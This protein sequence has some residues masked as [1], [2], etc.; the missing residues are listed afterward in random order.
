MRIDIQ[1]RFRI[2]KNTLI[3]EEDI[4]DMHFSL[5][6]DCISSEQERSSS[7]D[8]GV[9]K[10]GSNFSNSA[11]TSSEHRGTQQKIRSLHN[12]SNCDDF[13]LA[14][15]SDSHDTGIIRV[16][17]SLSLDALTLPH[18]GINRTEDILHTPKQHIPKPS[19]LPPE[20]T[21]SLSSCVEHNDKGI[22]STSLHDSSTFYSALA[23][24]D[25]AFSPACA[26][27]SQI[28][29]PSEERS[30]HT[31]LR[32]KRNEQLQSAPKNILIEQSFT[33]PSDLFMDL[34]QSESSLSDGSSTQAYQPEMLPSSPHLSIRDDS[35]VSLD[36]SQTE[37]PPD[38]CEED[39]ERDL[40]TKGSIQAYLTETMPYSSQQSN[41]DDSNASL[42]QSQT[43]SPPDCSEEDDERDLLIMGYDDHLSYATSIQAYLTE[44]MPSLPHQS[45]RSSTHSDQPEMFPSSPHLSKRDDSNVSI[46]V[47]QS[48][49]P[50]DCSEEDVNE[51]NSAVLSNDDQND[52][53]V[54]TNDTDLYDPLA[55]NE[56]RKYIDFLKSP[57]LFENLN[58]AFDVHTNTQQAAEELQQYYVS[59]PCL[60]S[61]TLEEELTSFRYIVHPRD[62]GSVLTEPE[63]IQDEYY[64]SIDDEDSED[65]E[66]EKEEEDLIWRAANLSLMD[67]VI[68]VLCNVKPPIFRTDLLITAIVQTCYFILHF[69]SSQRKRLNC[70]CDLLLHIH[71]ALPALGTLRLEINFL[72]SISGDIP[73]FNCQVTNINPYPLTE[74][75][76]QNLVLKSRIKYF[77]KNEEKHI[78]LPKLPILR[79]PF[80]IFMKHFLIFMF[81]LKFWNPVKIF[82]A[83]TERFINFVYHWWI[84][85][86]AKI[87]KSF[88][89][90]VRI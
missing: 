7:G 69:D 33:G 76:I 16:G 19:S 30:I 37:S 9:L 57:D 17:S 54:Q 48:E 56:L 75:D 60:K 1:K 10:V 52:V 21:F 90:D 84:K 81:S 87:I 2:V 45:N 83:S 28:S 24:N 32:V 6:P 36:Q 86:R 71:N 58:A 79:H 12:S 41:R 38:C 65:D 4:L 5:N 50:P 62:N 8:T 34:G 74:E 88:M 27:E 47:S 82:I 22:S 13:H 63:F 72:P 40:L 53:S 49:S 64:D 29:Y 42:D 35:N 51:P 25:D 89:D 85:Q 66:E 43:E 68:G 73:E 15:S 31:D 3:R 39:D 80:V 18:L 44:T 61:Y 23:K 78:K 77:P 55:V 46:D 11:S 14:K 70:T 67:T 59:R 20:E 26:V